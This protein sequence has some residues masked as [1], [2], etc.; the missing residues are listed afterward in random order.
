MHQRRAPTSWRFVSPPG[1][2]PG[3]FTWK[4]RAG[5]T[6]PARWPSRT[7]GGRRNWSTV[8][9][10]A[11]LPAGPQTLTLVE[12]TGGY[13]LHWFRFGNTVTAGPL[14]DGNYTLLNRADGRALDVS[15]QNTA[16]GSGLDLF[17]S[18]SQANQQWRLHGLGDGVYEILGVQSGRSLTV[19]GGLTAI[20]GP[21]VISDTRPARPA[22]AVDR[23]RWRLLQDQ[24]RGERSVAGKRCG[25][26]QHRSR[27]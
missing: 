22:M 12:D 26:R 20:G 11:A 2:A 10:T 9:T 7:P 14:P 24:R 8:T 13:N 3:G 25:R 15:A 4:T 18:N 1:S 21:V 17:T 23:H 5:A 19:S 27:R 6:C 16:N